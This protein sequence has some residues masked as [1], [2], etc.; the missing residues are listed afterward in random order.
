M[1]THLFLLFLCSA[2][3]AAA[4]K[5]PK[6]P[7]KETPPPPLEFITVKLSTM[8][9]TEF[10][11]KSIHVSGI[12]VIQLVRDSF[13]LGY[14]LKGIDAYVA[15][16]KPAKN[17]T[18]F[19]QDHLVKMYKY[20]FKEDG[21]RML[22]VI[23]DLRLGEKTGMMEYTYT[24]FAADG[25]ISKDGNAYKLI[26]SMDTVFV[27]E[28]SGDATNWHGDDIEFALKTFLRKVLPLAGPVLNNNEAGISVEEIKK[29][30]AR[31]TDYPIMK[32]TSYREGAYAGY[33][34]FLQN[35][36]S[37]KD[38]E[39]VVTD[40]KTISLLR[41]TTTK[42]TLAVWG[43]CSK[44]ELYRYYNGML[45]PIEVQGNGILISD[46]VEN[47]N[48]HNRNVAFF[49]MLG[50]AA[51][52]LV[53]GALAGGAASIGKRKLMLVDAIPYIRN[54]RKQPVASCINI[55]TGE[56]DF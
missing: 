25:Y 17:L 47:S 9:N 31:N 22:W 20:D 4:Q 29:R 21:A 26:G 30:S 46:F 36:P 5:K 34:E 13:R 32:D 27:G 16:L 23:R 7:V 43:L 19:L 55:D 3:L 39:A 18:S 42:D 40:K 14:A 2:S 38:Y 24:R 8:P 33:A 12:D 41:K 37:I 51:G 11:K 53:G 48:K 50:G 44:G 54:P 6:E 45:I 1:K 35:N 10:P 15:V 28:T 52:G 56:L 49:A